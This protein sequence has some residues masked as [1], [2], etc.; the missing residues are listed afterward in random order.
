MR[1]S[2]QKGAAPRTRKMIVKQ[3]AL[4]WEEHP[5]WTLGKLLQSA[6]SISRG[7]LK[8]NPA[9][10]RDMELFNGLKALIP[11]EDE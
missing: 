7:E 10:A 2:K 4:S 11:D 9:F 5:D 1:L 6:A 8:V 3:I